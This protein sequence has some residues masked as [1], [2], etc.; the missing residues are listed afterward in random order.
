MNL[1]ELGI[2]LA[3]GMIILEALAFFI[4]VYLLVRFI[5]WIV[6]KHR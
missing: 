2:L 5:M 4:F 6:K 3:I 1:F